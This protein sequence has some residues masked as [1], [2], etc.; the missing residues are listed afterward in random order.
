M[1]ED[2]RQMPRRQLPRVMPIDDAI[3]NVPWLEDIF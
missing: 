2:A 3:P 1:K